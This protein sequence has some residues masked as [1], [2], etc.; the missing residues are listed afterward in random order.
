MRLLSTV[1]S[2]SHDAL[3]LANC[4]VISCE[5]CLPCRN[6]PLKSCSATFRSAKVLRLLDQQIPLL[7][8]QPALKPS[9]EAQT[10]QL[11]VPTEQSLLVLLLELGGGGGGVVQTDQCELE[12]GFSRSG[13]LQL[14]LSYQSRLLGVGRPSPKLIVMDGLEEIKKAM[15]KG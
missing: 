11:E 3:A 13:P 10:L 9:L 12:S 14:P 4:C 1:I 2:T 8:P 7:A 15:R 5:P 6:S